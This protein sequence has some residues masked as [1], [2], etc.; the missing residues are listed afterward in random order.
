MSEQFGPNWLKMI[1]K[2]FLGWKKAVVFEFLPKY[3]TPPKIKENL[4]E[5]SVLDMSTDQIL[6]R[7]S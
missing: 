3:N 5:T 6:I 4:D 1:N 2:L 7:C